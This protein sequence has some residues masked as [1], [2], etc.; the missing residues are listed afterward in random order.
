MFNSEILF[1]FATLNPMAK[2][3]TIK[4]LDTSTEEKIKQAAKVVFTTKGYAAARTRDIAE[5][6]GINLALLNYYFRSKER[7]FQI[8][9]LE[10]LQT[11]FSSMIMVLN[12]EDLS[13]EKKV[14]G[15]VDRYITLFQ[16]QPDL[17]FFVVSEL[18]NHPE[19]FL[20]EM[21][22]KDVIFKSSFFR[23]L[24]VRMAAN[25]RLK[26]VNP[27]Q[28]LVNMSSMVI[29]PFA[30][31]PFIRQIGQL[32]DKEF[33]QLMEERKALIPQWILGMLNG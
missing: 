14:Q 6:A 26:G 31:A 10:S 9:M 17:P 12:D 25:P 28:M 24:Q 2:T 15:F 13:F 23:E 5:E 30:A 1:F 4:P 29:F 27:I 8:V 33:D 11:F 21:K 32:K 18:N 7:L 3:K 19:F 16:A 20:K 22:V